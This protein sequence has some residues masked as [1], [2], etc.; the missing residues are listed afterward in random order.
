MSREN[1]A[2]LE[3]HIKRDPDAHNKPFLKVHPTTSNSIKTDIDGYWFLYD[4]LG[5]LEAANLEETGVIEVN[6][7]WPDFGIL[8]T[9]LK[10]K[11]ATKLL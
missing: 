5:V 4:I 2:T 9:S 3:K 11:S 10:A 1:L 7:L 8:K 6:I